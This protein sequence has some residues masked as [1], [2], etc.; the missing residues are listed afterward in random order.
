MCHPEDQR[1]AGDATGPEHGPSAPGLHAGLLQLQDPG[2]L[3][4]GANPLLFQTMSKET[5]Y[6]DAWTC[7]EVFV[8]LSDVKNTDLCLCSRVVLVHGKVINSRQ[9]SE[10]AEK[11]RLSSPAYKSISNVRFKK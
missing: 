4:S 6:I 8:Q 2:R 5:L 3:G 10:G 11:W 9:T 1:A 7:C